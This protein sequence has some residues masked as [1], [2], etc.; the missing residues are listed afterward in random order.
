M[1]RVIR[2]DR[3]GPNHLAAD[4]FEAQRTAADLLQRAKVQTRQ[5]YCDAEQEI[6]RIKEKARDQGYKDGLAEAAEVLIRATA[7]RDQL[8]ASA[9]N[10]I[11]ELAVM[12]AERIINQEI[13]S[14]PEIINAI[15]LPLIS[16]ARRAKKVILRVHPQD[17]PTLERFCLEL[18]GRDASVPTEGIVV[19][20]DLS[21]AFQIEPDE[22][23]T[24]GGCIVV[25]DSGT[26]DARIEV[27]LESIAR[28]LQKE[29]TPR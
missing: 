19:E 26:F 27:Q 17:A 11:I 2:A 9:E 4:E 25:T 21:S 1:G 8:I 10:D 6:Q 12:A 16:R 22:T 14:S 28:L 15:V 18:I 24:R 5:L 7:S 20:S 29:G 23:I 13:S 3:E